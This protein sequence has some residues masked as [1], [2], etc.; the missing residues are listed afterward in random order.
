MD[1][2]LLDTDM[3]SEVL[4]QRNASVATNAAAYLGIHGQFSFSV[5]TR[6]E[7]ERGHKEKQ[8]DR[9]LARF[10]TFCQNSVVYPLRPRFS[11]K[12][13]TCG[14]LPGREATPMATP[15][16]LLPQPPWRMAWYW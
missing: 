16:C 3:L 4:K 7:I 12:P 5:F 9:L 15:I 14:Y 1:V 11:T 6:F 2:A 8:A 10:A 13:P